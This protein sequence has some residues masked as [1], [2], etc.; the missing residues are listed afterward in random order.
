MHLITEA[1]RDQQTHWPAAGRH[2][3]AQYDDATIVVYQ[4]YRPAIGHFAAR[5]G[6]FG[7]EFS[8]G[9][10]SWIK[11]NF[12]WMMY[13][14]GWGRK[15]GQEVTLAVRIQRT[16]FDEILRQAVPSTYQS[17]LYASE[18]EWKRA[19]EQSSVRVQW[20]PDHDPYGGRVTRRAIQLGLKGVVLENFGK[21][22]LSTIEDIT[23]FVRQQKKHVDNHR[24]D[25]LEVPVE[26]VWYPQ[27]TSIGEKIGAML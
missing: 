26:R 8:L 22:Q 7:G 14:N 25:L 1:Y 17:H 4:A 16:A 27:D 18:A 9:R 15:E 10:M 13:R 23:D 11:P 3:M 19:V 24:L 12:L 2:I 20:D 6:Y 21:R 5:N